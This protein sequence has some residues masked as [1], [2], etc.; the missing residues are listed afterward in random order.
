LEKVELTQ[1]ISDLNLQYWNKIR[2]TPTLRF[3]S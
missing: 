3:L 1:I 2:E